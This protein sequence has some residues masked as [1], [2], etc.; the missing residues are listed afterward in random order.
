MTSNP[1]LLQLPIKQPSNPPLPAPFQC[2]LPV[3]LLNGGGA[4]YF[5]FEG[6][7]SPISWPFLSFT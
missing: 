5:P 2:F 3:M 4:N 1:P 7:S 6:L